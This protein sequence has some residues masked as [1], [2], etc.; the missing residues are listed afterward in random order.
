M[1]FCCYS[2]EQSGI[3]QIF[4]TSTSVLKK[5]QLDNGIVSGLESYAGLQM[6]VTGKT[7]AILLFLYPLNCCQIFELGKIETMENILCFCN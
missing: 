1:L 6:A 5:R 7:D 2:I 3:Y 4:S